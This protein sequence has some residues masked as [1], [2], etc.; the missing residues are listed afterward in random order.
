[1]RQLRQLSQLLDS[2][3]VWLQFGIAIG[4]VAFSLVAVYGRIDVRFGAKVFSKIPPEEIQT[5]KSHIYQ[6]TVV[7]VLV[8]LGYLALLAG[9][10]MGAD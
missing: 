9:K 2:F 5:N 4:L 7:P 1:M 8:T 3:P 6:Y 10:Y